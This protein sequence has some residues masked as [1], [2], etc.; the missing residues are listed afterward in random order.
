MASGGTKRPATRSAGVDHRPVDDR[1]P[2]PARPPAADLTPVVTPA[3][4]T[5]RT[6][7]RRAAA[8]G[9]GTS[10]SPP[11]RLVRRIGRAVH[12]PAAED[13][14]GPHDQADALPHVGRL[15][16][17]PELI[18]AAERKQ[19]V[20]LVEIKAR[21]DEEANIVW[22]QARTGRRPRR[23]RP[24]RA[25]PLEAGA[26]VRREGSVRVGT[27]TSAPATTTRRPPACTPT[28][29]AVAGPS[30]CRCDRPVQR[31]DRPVAPARVPPPARRAAQPADP[32]PRPD[33]ARDRV[34]GGS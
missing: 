6:A 33:R 34:Q 21:F 28:S 24:R 5:R 1:Q 26:V 13:P 22:A 2:R 10:R 30:W 15:A 4:A 25:K 12:R 7:R 31:P 29:A 16:D 20:V 32:H 9:P 19:V 11:V 14:G 23:L 27:S 17:R 18:R 8:V 3:A